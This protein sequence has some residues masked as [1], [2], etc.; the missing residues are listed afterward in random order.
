MRCR[1]AALVPLSQELCSYLLSTF[2]AEYGPHALRPHSAT[3][4]LL[5]VRMLNMWNLFGKSVQCHPYMHMR[6]EGKL[7]YHHFLALLLG[8]LGCASAE[9]PST[10]MY[11][12]W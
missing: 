4:L 6:W 8:L 1:T 11:P 10:R 5:R 7:P 2:V 12:S 3:S 9:L